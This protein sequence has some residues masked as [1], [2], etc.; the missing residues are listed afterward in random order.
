MRR[1]LLRTLRGAPVVL[2]FCQLCPSL[3]RANHRN[4]AG[5]LHSD[6]VQVLPVDTAGNEKKRV[7]GGLVRLTGCKIK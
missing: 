6:V 1:A 2:S 7:R 5:L 4:T 3:S